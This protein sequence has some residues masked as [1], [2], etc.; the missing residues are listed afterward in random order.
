MATSNRATTQN[1]S[2]NNFNGSLPIGPSYNNYSLSIESGRENV[3]LIQELPDQRTINYRQDQMDQDNALNDSTVSM[4][5][6]NV[7]ATK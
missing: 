5:Q 6:C 1:R 4:N 3:S 2:Q 7:T